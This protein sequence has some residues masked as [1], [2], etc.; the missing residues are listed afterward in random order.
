MYGYILKYC[1]FLHSRSL[2]LVLY[3]HIINLSNRGVCFCV[4]VIWCL[5]M[6]LHTLVVHVGLVLNEGLL[7]E[8]L[9]QCHHYNYVHVWQ[10][11]T[12][13]PFWT[14]NYIWSASS[15]CAFHHCTIPFSVCRLPQSS[16][17]ALQVPIGV[18]LCMYI[19]TFTTYIQ[20]HILITYI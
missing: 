2:F 14:V 5:H 1:S 13:V 15:L 4:K 20:L 9:V 12:C 6:F 11:N 10:V 17:W 3:K 16:S 18:S 19:R 7:K 8:D